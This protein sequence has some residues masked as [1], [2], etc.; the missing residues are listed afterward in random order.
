MNPTLRQALQ[1]LGATFAIGLLLLGAKR[2]GLI[3]DD[4]FLRVFMA[5][6]GL[7]VAWY[8][9]LTPKARP[10]YTARRIAYRRVAGYAVTAA[11]LVNAAIWIWAP[12]AYAAELSMVP[13]AAAFLVALGYCVWLRGTAARA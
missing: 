2:I 8:G 5:L 7:V 9:N 6:I 13:L 4:G 3:D 10:A 11:G 12:M 1:T